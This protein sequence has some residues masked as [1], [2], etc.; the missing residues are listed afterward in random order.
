MIKYEVET[1]ESYVVLL[2]GISCV[3]VYDRDKTDFIRMTVWFF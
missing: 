3:A 1:E 2:F